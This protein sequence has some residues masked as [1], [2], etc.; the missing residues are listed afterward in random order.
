MFNILVVDDHSLIRK[1]VWYILS[2]TK[3]LRVTGEA[4]SAEEALDL[5]R[6]RRFD[7]IILDAVMPGRSGLDIIRDLRK[8][9]PGIKIIV[10]S[11]YNERQIA[12]RSYKEGADAFVCKSQTDGTL[13]PAIRD[14]LAG[15]RFVSGKL[16]TTW[17]IF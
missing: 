3:D 15:K 8:T 17:W 10:L 4:S 11:M 9:S 6:T 7:L 16:R 13:I 2:Q 12:L 14:V 5:V 1:G